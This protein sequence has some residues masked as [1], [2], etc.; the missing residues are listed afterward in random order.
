MNIILFSQCNL[1][2]KYLCMGL[3]L[4]TFS[5]I[6]LVAFVTGTSLNEC[7]DFI[8]LHLHS[9]NKYIVCMLCIFIF[10]CKS[11]CTYIATLYFN[12]FQVLNFYFYNEYKKQQ[13]FMHT[14]LKESV[15]QTRFDLTTR[16][17]YDTLNGIME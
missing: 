11:W 8:N 12:M 2:S 4:H 6:K 15:V 5:R 7:Y 3:V 1:H 9:K 10:F 14:Q 17:E 16:Y 13:T